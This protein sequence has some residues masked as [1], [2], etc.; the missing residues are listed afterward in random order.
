MN[1]TFCII[2][3]ALLLLSEVLS[4]VSIWSYRRKKEEDEPENK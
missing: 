4:T 3:V 1:D 2:F